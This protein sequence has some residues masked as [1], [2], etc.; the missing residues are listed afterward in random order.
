MIKYNGIRK[1]GDNMSDFVINVEHVDKVYKLYDSNRARVA[2]TLVFLKLL[3]TFVPLG[4]TVI[5]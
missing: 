2:D 4:L 3:N 1:I 5:T